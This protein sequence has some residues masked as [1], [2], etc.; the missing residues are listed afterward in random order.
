MTNCENC[1]FA[2]YTRHLLTGDVFVTCYGHVKAKIPEDVITPIDCVLYS[3]K[4]KG[5]ARIK[6]TLLFLIGR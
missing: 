6:D 3:K 4:L 5:I 2:S 1:R